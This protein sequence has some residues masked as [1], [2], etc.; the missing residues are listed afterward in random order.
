ML[1]IAP[2]LARTRTYRC[3]T[4]QG[5]SL[6][7]HASTRVNS[8]LYVERCV[9]DMH[10]VRHSHSHAQLLLAFMSDLDFTY[11]G[12]QSE[13][14]R[15]WPMLSPSH[16]LCCILAYLRAPWA[17][18]EFS[19]RVDTESGMCSAIA[20]SLPAYEQVSGAFAWLARRRG[21]DSG[22]ALET[23]LSRHVASPPRPRR[24]GL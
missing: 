6:D 24:G 1:R 16:C 20:L 8:T 4:R 17:E 5:S 23:H 9:S 19:T 22:A 12:D 14:N 13:P 21:A 7:T 15:G 18:T 2:S 3:P 10:T 11:I